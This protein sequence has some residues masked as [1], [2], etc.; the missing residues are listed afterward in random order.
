MSAVLSSLNSGVCRSRQAPVVDLTNV[1]KSYAGGVAALR[2]VSLIISAGEAVA[3]TG[4]SGSGKST[5]LNMIGMLDRPTSGTVSV[6]GRRTD[7][8]TDSQ[9][10]ALRGKALGFVFQQFNLTDGASAWQNVCTGLLYTGTP[11]KQRRALAEQALVRVGLSHR[12]N[13]RP[14]E[15]SGG[16]RQR[17]AIAR[18]IAHR[19]SLLLAD[20]PTGALDTAS[21]QSVMTL[22]HQL[23]LDGT[24]LA[25]ITHDRGV[26]EQMSRRI[27]VRDGRI[28]GDLS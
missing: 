14:H 22:L 3:I 15:M 27:T 11:R 6:R 17:V 23:N 25:V 5:L 13:H 16:E 12:I 1:T 4:P 8:L 21:G 19:P 9:V 24:T 26:A 7:G 2:G 18:A 28:V 10:S 20:E